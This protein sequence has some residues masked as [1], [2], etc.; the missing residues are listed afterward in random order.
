MTPDE[1][2]LKA[3]MEAAGYHVTPSGLTTTDACAAE[4]G[5]KPTTLRNW[6]CKDRGPQWIL[7]RRRPWYELRAICDWKK[8]NTR[9][10]FA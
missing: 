10:P 2:L 9:D 8:R 6:R 4:L 3:R 7:I 5:I 1:L